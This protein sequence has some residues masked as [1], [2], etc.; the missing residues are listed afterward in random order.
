MF[1]STS[2]VFNY[3]STHMHTQP[4]P[5]LPLPSNN[6]D[7]GHQ[8]GKDRSCTYIPI[9]YTYIF[10]LC[11]IMKGILKLEFSYKLQ[12]IMLLHGVFYLRYLIYIN[13]LRIIY[14][15]TNSIGVTIINVEGI[16][17]NNPAFISYKFN[18]NN[19]C[20]SGLFSGDNMLCTSVQCLTIRYIF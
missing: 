17:N 10:L 2:D 8:D 5:P 13:D 6:K 7:N 19:S 12:V 16:N 11:T 18:N 4:P 1:L 20:V 14:V 15:P 3:H 9:T